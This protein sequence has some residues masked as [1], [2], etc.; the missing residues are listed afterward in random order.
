MPEDDKLEINRKSG[1]A[2]AAAF[3]LFAAVI[4]GL[5]AIGFSFVEQSQWP[6]YTG[7]ILAAAAFLLAW[8][9]QAPALDP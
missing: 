5:L 6:T 7:V 8:A 2:Y 1:L 9:F 3:S 4:A